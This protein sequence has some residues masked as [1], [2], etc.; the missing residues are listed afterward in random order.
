MIFLSVFLTACA[1]NSAKIRETVAGR[2][3]TEPGMYYGSFEPYSGL[4][5]LGA[6]VSG[7]EMI[8]KLSGEILIEAVE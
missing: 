4:Y 1:G 8:G 7:S 2:A 5:E 3:E 6:A